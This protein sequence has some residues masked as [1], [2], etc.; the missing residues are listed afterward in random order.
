MKLRLVAAVVISSTLVFAGSASSSYAAPAGNEVTAIP[1]L[2]IGSTFPVPTL[3]MA[4]NGYARNITQLALDTLMK[5]GPDGQVEPDLASSVTQPNAVTY[6][7]HLRH[8]VKF[9][10][11]SDLTSADVVYSLD[12]QRAIGSAQSYFFA[13]VKSIVASGPD[14]VVVTLTHPDASWQYGPP[15]LGIFEMKFAEAHKAK[16]GQPGVLLMGSG[17]W[18]VQSL[19][20]TTGAELTANPNWWGGPVPVQHISMKFFTNPSSE[21][22]AFRAGQVD[23][24]PSIVAPKAFGATSGAT[25]LN[26][27]SDTTANFFTI[28][29]QAPG[30]DDV[31]VRRAVAYALN[32][33]DLVIA[34]G[35]YATPLYTTVTPFELRTIGS[36]AQVTALLNS[37]NLYPHNLAKAKAEMAASAYPHGFTTTLWEYNWGATLNVVQVIAAELQTIGINAQI[38]VAPSIPAFG[39]VQ[40]G[41]AASRRTC[42]SVWGASSPD[43][44]AFVGEMLGSWNLKQGQWNVSDY[45]PPQLDKLLLDG[46]E[47]TNAAARFSVYSQILRQL[48]SSVPIVPLF[49]QDDTVAISNHYRFAGL[50][51]YVLNGTY[52]LNITRVA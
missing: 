40:T 19:D 31:H 23:F 44:S 4:R 29:T 46:I 21:A 35:G 13:S 45:A 7:Y 11:G 37:L 12:Y 47:T 27:P 8:G 24:D 25:L 1:L 14:A 42:F 32:R 39:A 2:T 30:W 18:E 52:P 6:V 28:N 36:Q 9:W 22:L 26:T 3:D 43:A 33:A 10:D 20:P 17:P 5:F 41:P 34:N 51:Q 49:G 15:Y 50:N 38:K 48:S 16:F